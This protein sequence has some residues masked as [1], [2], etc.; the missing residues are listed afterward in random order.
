M[1]TSRDVRLWAMKWYIWAPGS[2]VAGLIL[3]AIAYQVLA[4]DSQSGMGEAILWFGVILCTAGGL[5]AM[6]AI[7]LL[8]EEAVRAG[9]GINHKLDSL[10][11]LVNQQ[12]QLLGEISQSAHLSDMAKE[13][14]Y[15]DM[16]RKGLREAVLAKLHQLDFAGTFAL[17]ENIAHRPGY[18]NLAEE[19]KLEAD[20]YR[21]ANESERR[22]QS[23]SYIEKLFEN[24]QWAQARAQIE[25]Y[26]KSFDD[27][28]T[29]ESMMR[30]LNGLRDERKRELMA[31][32]ND[33][34]KK[35]DVD[36]SLLILKE[37]D[38]YLTQAEG[39]ALQ[40]SAR[41]VFR[42][43][44]Q[45]LGVQFSLA[46]NEKRWANALEIGEEI[47]KDFPNT[48]MA[49]EIRDGIEAIRQRAGKDMTS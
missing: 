16:D 24:S 28:G 46:V 17:I 3:R 19:L 31:K 9:I 44:L 2:I 15:R 8:A 49:Q 5:V 1:D 47:M 4:G 20:K 11:T 48:K 32:W 23:I 14:I 43:K 21:G 18:K 45:S 6:F 30:K 38:G 39:M 37:L 22:T 7:L 29:A 27:K 33:S 12:R 13:V 40:E 10:L 34:V 25:S 42:S 41:E 35:Q 36:A 26:A